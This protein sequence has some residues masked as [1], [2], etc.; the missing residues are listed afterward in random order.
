MTPSPVDLLLAGRNG[1]PF[2][3]LGPHAAEGGGWEVR[4]FVP[5]AAAVTVETETAAIAAEM[6][7]E[8]GYFVAKTDAYPGAYRLRVNGRERC[9][10]ARSICT[11]SARGRTSGP[12]IS[13]ARTSRKWRVWRESGS[14]CGRRTLR[15]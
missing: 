10:S 7:H 1:D 5:H 4:V 6:V 15:W 12:T 11:C 3:L 14:R 13:S 9:C 8:Q 2:A